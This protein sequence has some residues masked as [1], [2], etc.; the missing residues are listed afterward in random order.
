MNTKNPTHIIDCGTNKATMYTAK[1]NK[2]VSIKNEDVLKLP[3]KLPSGSFVVSE[4]SH[5]GCQ[6]TDFSLS[7]PFTSDELLDLYCRFEQYGITLKLF[8]QKSTP[9]ACAYSE[10]SKDDSTDPVAIYNLLVDFPK[11]SLMNPPKTFNPCAVREE[12]YTYKMYTDKFINM[13]RREKPESY[14]SDFCSKFIRNNMD[15]IEKRLSEDARS[16]FKLTEDQNARYKSNSI[17]HGRN[18]G[19]W[20]FK[21]VSMQSIY[22]IACTIVHP[23]YENMLRVRPST[24]ELPGWKYIKKYIIKMTPFH[25]K[26]GV[27]RSNLYYHGMKNWIAWR[28]LQILGISNFKKKSRGGHWQKEGAEKGKKIIPDTRFTPEEDLFFVEQR[29]IYCN[30]IKELW[31]VIRD[32]CFELD[33]QYEDVNEIHK[34]ESLIKTLRGLDIEV[35]EKMVSESSQEF[36]V[37]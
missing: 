27:A 37:V 20:N 7:Q 30:A 12:S 9:R 2:V 21:N 3:E 33:M 28:A 16:C 1:D 23:E 10:L 17:K 18:K 34:K 26:G 4:Y 22:A 11:T 6:R 32:I 24:G 8:P 29:I 36:L 35:L 14:S 19:D 15:E 5:L 25:L 13:A 31:C